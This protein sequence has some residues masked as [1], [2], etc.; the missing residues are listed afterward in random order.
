MRRILLFL[1]LSFASITWGN[2]ELLSFYFEPGSAELNGYSK[3]KIEGFQQ[4][5]KESR[6]QVLEIHAF[7]DMDASVEANLTLSQQR[8]DKLMAQLKI[9]GQGL[10]VNNYGKRKIVLD[11]TPFNWDRVDVYYNNEE[12]NQ[13]EHVPIGEQITAPEERMM[14]VVGV[15]KL[16]EISLNVPI[17]IPVKFKAESNTLEKGSQPRLEQ[18]YATMVKFPELS[19]HIRGHVCCGNKPLIS[20]QRAK[21]VYSYLKERGINKRRLSFK[22]YSNTSP[23][24]FPEKSDADRTT[25]RRVEVVFS[26]K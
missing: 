14:M 26:K 18:L 8:A 25:N 2:V 24:I 20:R 11:F 4:L 13:S 3:L 17:I 15:P 10:I 22:G 9:G 5:L 23:L 12:N 19:V 21:V 7:S 16:E 6:I 1:A